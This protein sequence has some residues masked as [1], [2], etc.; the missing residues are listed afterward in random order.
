MLVHPVYNWDSDCC[1]CCWACCSCCFCFVVHLFLKQHSV[2][3]RFF[4]TSFFICSL[5]FFFYLQFDFL[6]SSTVWLSF[7]FQLFFF[8]VSF[9]LFLLS[10]FVVQVYKFAFFLDNINQLLSLF[11]NDL[12][13]QFENTINRFFLID[14]DLS[15]D[16]PK[17]LKYVVNIATNYWFLIGSFSHR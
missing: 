12:F 8:F 6:H 5:L 13:S 3:F 17:Q 16:F 11:L 14:Q 7:F 9:S 2:E 15:A 10:L 1:S 4:L